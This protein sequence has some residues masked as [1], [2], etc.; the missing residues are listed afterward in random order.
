MNRVIFSNT[1]YVLL[2]AEV[3]TTPLKP[4]SLSHTREQPYKTPFRT[5]NTLPDVEPLVQ[6]IKKKNF[7]AFH[8]A[9]CTGFAL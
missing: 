6:Q 4:P 9:S 7:V 2:A 5:P 8:K 1:L 3:A